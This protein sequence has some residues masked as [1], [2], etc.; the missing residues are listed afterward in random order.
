MYYYIFIIHSSADGHQGCFQLLVVK[1]KAAMNIDKQV[2][3]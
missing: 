3:L 1:N 2:Y